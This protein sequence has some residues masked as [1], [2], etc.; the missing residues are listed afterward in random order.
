MAYCPDAYPNFIGDLPSAPEGVP[1]DPWTAGLPDAIALEP[2]F[3]SV[4]RDGRIDSLE[5][6]YAEVDS[7]DRMRPVA[8]TLYVDFKQRNTRSS[9]VRARIPSGLWGMEDRGGYRY[10]LFVTTRA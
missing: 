6:R 7:T 8:V 3:H 5:Y 10:D 4:D 9:G 2:E 1:F